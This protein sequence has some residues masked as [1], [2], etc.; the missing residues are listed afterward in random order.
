MAGTALVRHGVYDAS[1]GVDDVRI[2][3]EPDDDLLEVRRLRRE[4][5]EAAGRDVTAPDLAELGAIGQGAAGAGS[6]RLL[7]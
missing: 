7:R 4:E 3:S 2:A 1:G 5:G 6:Y